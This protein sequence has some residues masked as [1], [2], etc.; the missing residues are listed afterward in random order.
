MLK[1]SADDVLRTDIATPFML[2]VLLSSLAS[3]YPDFVM[4]VVDEDSEF[5]IIRTPNEP[6]RRYSLWTDGIDAP[7]VTRVLR[8][9]SVDHRITGSFARIAATS[10]MHAGL[11]YEYIPPISGFSS[12]A[13]GRSYSSHILDDTL[14]ETS[15]KY[16]ATSRI[17]FRTGSLDSRRCRQSTR[18]HRFDLTA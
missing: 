8:Y 12:N 9:S 17:Q 14:L 5:A 2:V 15:A 18:R 1:F 13:A 4:L 6:A 7:T 3:L 11:G 10:S 16:A